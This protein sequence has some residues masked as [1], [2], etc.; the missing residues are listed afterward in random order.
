MCA[1]CKSSISQP[2]IGQTIWSNNMCN[3]LLYLGHFS[4]RAHTYLTRSADKFE[5]VVCNLCYDINN[6]WEE[7]IAFLF[8]NR[9]KKVV[10]LGKRLQIQPPLQW[11]CHSS[12]FVLLFKKDAAN[13]IASKFWTYKSKKALDISLKKKK[14]STRKIYVRVSFHYSLFQKKQCLTEKWQRWTT[15][16]GRSK[17]LW[18]HSVW[19][20]PTSQFRWKINSN[21]QPGPK[22]QYNFNSLSIPNFPLPWINYFV[23]HTVS[24]AISVA[25]SIFILFYCRYK[26]TQQSITDVRLAAA[27]IFYGLF[28]YNL[29]EVIFKETF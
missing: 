10:M 14:I 20:Q 28:Q 17:V 8:Y 27:M 1:S 13:Q 24:A 12:A 18:G 4:A 2:T 19:S 6:E 22:Q 5:K 16:K 21:C 9:K 11:L 29:A 3:S 15:T 26:T 23:V 7:F 25:I